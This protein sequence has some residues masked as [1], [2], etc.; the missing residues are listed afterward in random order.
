MTNEYARDE[1]KDHE[2]YQIVLKAYNALKAQQERTKNDINYLKEQKEQALAN[3]I[4]YIDKLFNQKKILLP[5]RQHIVRVPNIDTSK[6]A[7]PTKIL[8]KEQ[9]QTPPGTP[10]PNDLNSPSLS[11][12]PSPIPGGAEIKQEI[13]LPVQEVPQP[14]T[15]VRG[16]IF[17]ERKPP[18]F[19][20]L[21]TKEEQRR[22][23]N[24]LIEYPDE[25]VSA[26]RWAKIARALGN[27]TPK[28]VASRTQKY[29]IRLQKQ[30]I[31]VPG[32]PPSMALY[33]NKIN[34]TPNPPKKKRK[35]DD[36]TEESDEMPTSSTVEYYVP[37][38]V[39]MREDRRAKPVAPALPNE[40]SAIPAALQDTPEYK[41]L[42]EL[43]KAQQPEKANNER[44]IPSETLT[45][46]AHQ[47][48]KCDGCEVEPIVGT[49]WHCAEC[50]EVDLCDAC[51]TQETETP[52][53]RKHHKM[54]Q[55][56]VAEL[57]PYYMDNDYKYE[58][59]FGESNYLDPR[60]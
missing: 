44:V 9:I 4:E 37:P 27:R 46:D 57:T 60:A 45:T 51:H 33:L 31:P 3:P 11:P 15:V 6:Y 35:T 50:P 36:D 12:A 20:Q 52:T 21:W 38:P 40:L 14:G 16:R 32:K 43:L 10:D 25:E 13:E 48:Y 5:R 42:M 39:L 28:Q 56:K 19:N 7:K 23:E 22:L 34:N 24:L 1:L 54:E 41:E 8:I 53:H 26:H 18:S 58:Y 17:T 55:F 47:G 59:Q 2:D 49:R 30:G 29:F